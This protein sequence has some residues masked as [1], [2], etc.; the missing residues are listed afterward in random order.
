MDVKSLGKR[1]VSGLVYMAL[2]ICGV[3][4]GSTTLALLALLLAVLATVEFNHIATGQRLSPEGLFT[5]TLDCLAAAC[6]V[7]MPSRVSTLCLA[8]ILLC[9]GVAEL[10]IKSDITLRR[11]EVSAT[12]L[13]YIAA[14]IMVMR[15]IP[16]LFGTTMPVMMIF[17]MIWLNDTGAFIV[18]SACGRHSLFKRLSPKK[19]WEG[20]A[21][22]LILN[23][24][25][26]SAMC[27]LCPPT[28]M[29]GAGIWTWTG[30]AMTVSIFSTWGD[31]FESMIKRALAIKDSGNIIPGHGGILDRIDSML[32]VMPACALFFYLTYF[33]LNQ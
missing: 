2:I 3:V 6:V 33:I 27:C 12:T 24:M 22:G 19:S 21:G 18:G 31:L 26:A 20:F 11:L 29:P 10:Y 15:N 28:W 8:V 5:L 30:L 25:A 13:I 16:M 32:F 17:I 7:M 23:I 1:T 9:R 4:C 14:P